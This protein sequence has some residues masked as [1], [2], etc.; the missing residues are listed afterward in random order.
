MKIGVKIMYSLFFVLPLF[1][2]MLQKPKYSLSE[3]NVA[4]FNQNNILSGDFPDT[5]NLHVNS[6][7]EMISFQDFDI[8]GVQKA[9]ID[10]ISG[11]T[12]MKEFAYIFNDFRRSDDSIEH[13]AIFYRKERFEVLDKGDFQYNLQKCAESGEKN[14]FDQ[15]CSW[16]RLKDIHEKQVFVFFSVHFEH[17]G[18]TAQQ[19]LAEMTITRIH[20]VAKG[21]PIVLVGGL[22]ALPSS[23]IYRILNIPL[24]DAAVV[25]ETAPYGLVRKSKGFGGSKITTD[26]IDYIFVDDVVNVKKYGVLSDSEELRDQSDHYPVF[27][28]ISIN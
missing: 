1:S 12:A 21:D 27:A 11:L 23:E 16:V 28:R 26:R 8:L 14:N 10:K 18:T 20:E 6:V 17:L 22:N 5:W 25:S 9:D 7:K 15:L 2:C 3:I 24:N 19:K 13:S 4:S